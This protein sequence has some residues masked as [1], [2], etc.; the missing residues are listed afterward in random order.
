MFRVQE[1]CPLSKSGKI[2]SHELRWELGFS[3]FP[4]HR[5]QT[6]LVSTLWHK[7]QYHPSQKISYGTTWSWVPNSLGTEKPR[8]LST[9]R[10]ALFKKN[11]KQVS[12]SPELVTYCWALL[13]FLPLMLSR[14]ERCLGPPEDPPGIF[15]V[16]S[17]DQGYIFTKGRKASRAL[18]G[19]DW[20]LANWSLVLNL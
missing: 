15:T 13:M 8:Q 18:L 11:G 1:T 7:F 4:A 19:A 16:Y 2:Q 12:S 3:P 17:P 10:N 5:L 6:Q 20:A 14:H 9:F